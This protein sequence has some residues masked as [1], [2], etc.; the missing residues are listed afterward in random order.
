MSYK[1]VKRGPGRVCGFRLEEAAT[2]SSWVQM[3][4]DRGSWR[5]EAGGEDSGG[6]G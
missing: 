1:V 5:W 3:S 6:G 2:I 4:V